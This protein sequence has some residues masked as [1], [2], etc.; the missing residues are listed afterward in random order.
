[1]GRFRSIGRETDPDEVRMTLGEHLEELRSR[2]IKALLAVVVCTILCYIFVDQIMG[3]LTSPLYAALRQQGQLSRI[4]QTNPSEAFITSL[5][6]SIIVGAILSAPISL[7]Q[8][9]GFVAAGLYSRERRWVRRFAP[10]SIALFFL[11]AAFLFIVCSPLLLSFLI[12]Y[13]NQLPNYED[14]SGWVLGQPPALK[15]AP[16]QAPW[17]TTQPIPMFESDPHPSPEGVPWLNLRTREVRM[18]VGDK[19]YSVSHLQEVERVNRVESMISISEYVMF[20]L[21][22]AAAF[23]VGFQV[24][25]VVAFLATLGIMTAAQM[26]S[27]RQYIWFGMAITAAV[28]TPPDITSMMLLLLPMALLLEIGLFVARLIERRRA[29]AATTEES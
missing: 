11:G 28:I 2:L 13:Q 6:V 25:V 20:I 4:V 10:T 7:W 29:E 14:L 19:Y 22:L 16:E 3:F 1:M 18:R 12:S 8:I 21:Q 23:G 5:R 9:W 15:P 24:P 26:G 17:P 27:M